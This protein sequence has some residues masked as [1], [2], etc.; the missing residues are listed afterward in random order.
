MM[1][2]DA[3]TSARVLLKRALAAS[4]GL[5]TKKKRM[6]ATDTQL[7]GISWPKI[8]LLNFFMQTSLNFIKLT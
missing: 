4:Y 7:T 8:S 5:T 6:A 1:S 2:G 3:L